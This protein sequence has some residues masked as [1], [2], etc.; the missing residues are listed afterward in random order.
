[1]VPNAQGGDTDG[2]VP[3]PGGHGDEHIKV[4]T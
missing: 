2:N 1:M 4:V 3:P